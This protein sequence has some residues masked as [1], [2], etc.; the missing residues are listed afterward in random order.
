[1]WLPN[2]VAKSRSLLSLPA[3]LGAGASLGM[4]TGVVVG[5]LA[6]FLLLSHHP[7]DSSADVIR[8][9]TTQIMHA[10]NSRA[11]AAAAVEGAKASASV[12]EHGAIVALSRLAASRARVRVVS[13]DDL[14]VTAMPNAESLLVRVPTPVVERMRFDSAAV[15][16]LGM[17]VQRKETVIVAQDRR[18]TADSLEL[19]ATSNALS[20]LER[21][22]QPRCGRKCGIVLGVGGMLAAAV[23]VGQV[24]RTFR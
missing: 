5:L 3:R 7:N 24:R 18:I 15:A 1:M 16:A 17:L 23:A 4:T 19:A 13:A 22:K 20:A 14:V 2:W 10:E 11:A 8:Q 21:V 9:A 12:A 6:G